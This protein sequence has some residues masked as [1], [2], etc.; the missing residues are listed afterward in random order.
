[1]KGDKVLKILEIITDVGGEISEV[2]EA[3]LTAG[4]G[5][6]VKKIEYR[7][8]EIKKEKYKK[9]EREK[10]RKKFNDLIYLLKKDGLIRKEKKVGKKILFLTKKGEDKKEELTIRKDKEMPGIKYKQEKSKTFS[11]ISFD[12]PERERRKRD[13][14]R[15]VLQ[16]LGFKMIQKSVWIGK[17]EIP[18]EFIDDLFKLKMDE[19]VEI[20]EISKTGSLRH[21]I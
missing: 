21:L 17:I 4:Y 12:I 2:L 15:C 1:M 14:V 6:S 9:E 20:F 19:Y 18:K 7:K 16:N 8:S 10:R 5:A 13:W 3:V 11:I